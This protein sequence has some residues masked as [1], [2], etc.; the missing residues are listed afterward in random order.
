M[1]LLAFSRCF[2][3][4]E[5]R[6]ELRIT[7]HRALSHKVRGEL[8]RS[9]HC[10]SCARQADL[11]RILMLLVKFHDEWNTNI[12]I[13][14]LFSSARRRIVV[15]V[16]DLLLPMLISTVALFFASFLSWMVLP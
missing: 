5:V 11:P 8:R 14:D 16:V 9:A 1:E 7:F 4:H 6:G 12:P 10:R 2:H 13:F 15:T 3:G